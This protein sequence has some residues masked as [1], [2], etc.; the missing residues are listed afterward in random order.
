MHGHHHDHHH[1]PPRSYNTAFAVAVTLNLCFS[2]VEAVYAILANSMSL[3]A[4]AGHNFGDVLG[5]IMAWGS[6]LLLKV[7]SSERYSYGFK[8]TTILAALANALLLVVTSALIAFES[9][10]KL[11]TPT[12]V[13][14][15]IVI[16]LALL[17]IVINGCTA[18]PFLK[19]RDHDLNIKGAFLHL[20]ADALIALGVVIV[21]VI[22]R[23]TAWWWLDPV[24]GLLIVL[25]ILWGTWGLLRDSVNLIL[26]AVPHTIDQASVRDYLSKIS[27]VETV[28]DLHIWGLS[29]HETALTAH[30]IMPERSLTDQDFEAINEVLLHRFRINHVTIQVEKGHRVDPCGQT[31]KC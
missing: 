15:T 8:K 5:L 27:G 28:H 7:A 12:P 1:P 30:L 14:E 22:V 25:T 4:D 16:W 13:N 18:L 26:D 9:I 11:M 21:A 3:L 10:N 20:A 31:V 19:G 17:A 23:F 24:V 2:I 6:S 29:T